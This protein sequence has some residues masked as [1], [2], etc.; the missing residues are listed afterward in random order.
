MENVVKEVYAPKPQPE[1]EEKKVELSVE[2]ADKFTDYPEEIDLSLLNWFNA[3]DTDKLDQ[4][5]LDKVKT[6]LGYIKKDAGNESGEILWT[7]R[8]IENKLNTPPMG[9]SR[10]DHI[11]QYVRLQEEAERAER[12]AQAYLR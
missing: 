5:Y 12:V 6:I 4:K 8:H 7:L 2:H 3:T 9:T 1:P 11:Y 10:V